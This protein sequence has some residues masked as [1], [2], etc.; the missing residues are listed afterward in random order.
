MKSVTIKNI[1]LFILSSAMLSGCGGGGGG[2]SSGDS[3]G[4]VY[5]ANLVGSE[6]ETN[7]TVAVDGLKATYTYEI[8]NYSSTDVIENI[9]LENASGYQFDYNIENPCQ[10]GTILK[11]MQSCQVKVIETDITESENS[12]VV[13]AGGLV[14]N[15]S[16]G[17]V[18][19]IKLNS[20]ELFD[21]KIKSAN[22]VDQPTTNMGNL[23]VEG[24][25]DFIMPSQLIISY[26][27]SG[28]TSINTPQL[29]FNKSFVLGQVDSKDVL[30]SDVIDFS[31]SKV[32]SNSVLFAGEKAK[33]PFELSFKKALSVDQMNLLINVLNHNN[34]NNMI[35]LAGSNSHFANLDFKV[36]KPILVE[37]SAKQ[38]LLPF[39]NGYMPSVFL[40]KV[41]NHSDKQITVDLSSLNNIDDIEVD[42]SSDD[43]CLKGME[44]NIKI[45]DA[46]KSCNLTYN[47]KLLASKIIPWSFS[48]N[49]DSYQFK[50]DAYQTDIEIDGN[51]KIAL[52]TPNEIKVFS[53]NLSEVE[54]QNIGVDKTQNGDFIGSDLT[55]V[56]INFNQ[57]S[58][59]V[60]KA[61]IEII[62]SPKTIKV[63]EK[64]KLQ[65]KVAGN[66]QE[67][68]QFIND[69]NHNETSKLITVTAKNKAGGTVSVAPKLIY[70]SGLSISGSESLLPYK[71]FNYT[72]TNDE[73]DDTYKIN[74]LKTDE[75]PQGISIENNQCL[76]ELKPNDTCSFDLK[77]DADLTGNGRL[78]IVFNNINSQESKHSLYE[79][80]KSNVQTIEVPYSSEGTAKV[81]RKDQDGEFITIKLPVANLGG[82]NAEIIKDLKLSVNDNLSSIIDA[83]SVLGPIDIEVNETKELVLVFKND[84]FTSDQIAII[85]NLSN[86]AFVLKAEN[87]IDKVIYFNA[88]QGA[89]LS[90]ATSIDKPGDYI[91]KLTNN[92]KQ[93][94]K[95]DEIVIDQLPNGVSLKDETCT[96]N[97]IQNGQ[98][99]VIELNVLQNAMF[100]KD[101]KNNFTISYNYQESQ[102]PSSFLISS[103]V[104]IPLASPEIQFENEDNNITDVFLTGKDQTI[105]VAMK[106]TSAFDMVL[107]DNIFDIVDK[108]NQP[109]SGFAINKPANQTVKPNETIN[110]EITQSK[111]AVKGEYIFR[112]SKADDSNLDNE[113][114]KTLFLESK[115]DVNMLVDQSYSESHPSVSRILVTN[116]DE[117]PVNL[118]VNTQNSDYIASDNKEADSCQ[119]ILDSGKSCAYYYKA[120]KTFNPED[121]GKLKDI[122]VTA[123]VDGKIDQTKTFELKSRSF[124]FDM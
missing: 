105:K 54:V 119:A 111:D 24:S 1:L 40:G 96:A 67:M 68:A 5:V 53:G 122:T 63:G 69:L 91:Y 75:L 114:K 112:I 57:G 66:D 86:P 35:R 64:V 73:T 47:S 118:S 34:T 44:N 95:V 36:K 29:N 11:H 115:A 103:N 20:G 93:A 30:L 116:H 90:S 18:F 37:V 109:I 13:P 124:L 61:I 6:D 92:D 81:L 85:E 12:T 4:G 88:P 39:A 117:N 110:F 15:Q 78:E 25:L 3:G 100:S 89:S 60:G 9:Q 101:K 17:P 38:A 22:R 26:K 76:V 10:N 8:T 45:L 83:S 43:S 82:D 33:E 52:V 87:I 59:G 55:E 107:N 104:D 32:I 28:N 79:N 70:D 72:I 84:I 123:K 27:N 41:T 80:L 113:I 23:A 108:N 77:T 16:N 102:N 99:C 71:Q 62:D 94:I 46:A 2:G 7:P 106:N 49:A 51:D 42:S 14:G 31:Q 50:S 58:D 121:T 97:S 65:F 120:I 56:Q 98:S 21:F 19:K 48:Y 74:E